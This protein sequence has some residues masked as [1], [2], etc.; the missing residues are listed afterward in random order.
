MFKTPI[1]PALKFCLCFFLG[2]GKMGLDQDE[3]HCTF[4]VHVYSCFYCKF[5]YFSKITEERMPALNPNKQPSVHFKRAGHSSVFDKTCDARMLL[6]TVTWLFIPASI[7]FL[8]FKCTLADL[9][10][11]SSRLEWGLLAFRNFDQ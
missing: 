6:G 8:L 11:I 1:C 5:T 10:S 4:C 3:Q 2:F 7:H 9:F